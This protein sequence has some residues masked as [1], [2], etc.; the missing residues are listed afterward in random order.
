MVSRRWVVGLKRAHPSGVCGCTPIS[1]SHGQRGSFSG[2]ISVHTVFP[3]S[4][5]TA[6]C[7]PRLTSPPFC[8]C[9]LLEVNAPR[10]HFKYLSRAFVF[11]P[12][13]CLTYPKMVA[14]LSALRRSADIGAGAGRR[15][16]HDESGAV[17]PAFNHIATGA[18]CVCYC[19]REVAW[20]YG[21]GIRSVTA[22]SR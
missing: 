2:R 15:G 14:R 1:A 11:C 12:C 22:S 10:G 17:M 20:E 4:D 21:L 9:D 19:C 5:R 13:P 3:A 18:G 16:L 7:G 6:P 8:L